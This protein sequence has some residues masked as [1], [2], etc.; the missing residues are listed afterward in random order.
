MV[1][2]VA[3]ETASA[4]PPMALSINYLAVLSESRTLHLQS[5]ARTMMEQVTISPDNTLL[6]N[7]VRATLERDLLVRADNFFCAIAGFRE[8]IAV[9]SRLFVN[10]KITLLWCELNSTPTGTQ[11]VQKLRAHPVQQGYTNLLDVHMRG[12]LETL[13]A[14]KYHSD[15]LAVDKPS[16]SEISYVITE[17]TELMSAIHSIHHSCL[18]PPS[19]YIFGGATPPVQFLY[20]MTN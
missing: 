14:C 15:Y 4:R 1:D 11:I 10:R 13:S 3:I 5:S 17:Q 8:T 9:N 19:N 12:C 16:S 20:Y 2:I 18:A 7:P 6:H